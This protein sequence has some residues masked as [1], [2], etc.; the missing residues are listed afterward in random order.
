MTKQLL[1]FT[2]VWGMVIVLF[3]CVGKLLFYTLINFGDVT[4]SLTFL[5]QAALANWDL[6]QFLEPR[7]YSCNENQSACFSRPFLAFDMYTGLIYMLI[8][9]ILNIVIIMNLVI[10][11]LSTT[12]SQY[13]N[14]AR[15]LYYDT[16]IESLSVYIHHKHYGALVS[17]P[18]LLSPLSLVLA[19]VF[20]LLEGSMLK[21]VNRFVSLVYYAPIGLIATVVF[22]IINLLCLPLAFGI[23]VVNK[24]KMQ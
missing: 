7:V 6:S 20:N 14:Y 16:I 17:G 11:I 21:R 1:M 2:V 9:L 19:F 15:G 18:S 23:I 4:T 22:F 24:I 10:A 5:I 13:S 8:F 12:Y 3:T